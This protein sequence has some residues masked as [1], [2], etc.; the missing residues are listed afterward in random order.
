MTA[1]H[2]GAAVGPVH[3]G[4]GVDPPATVRY[5]VDAIGPAVAFYTGQ[6]GF[7]LEHRTDRSAVLKDIK[8]NLTLELAAPGAEGARP[9]PAGPQE[10]GGWTRIVVYVDDLQDTIDRL[11]QSGVRFRSELQHGPDG[12]E[13][14]IDDPDGNAVELHSMPK[15]AQR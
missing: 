13:I 2:A 8:D 9:T 3:A 6:L 12:A 4:A 5:Q 14:V 11:H 10:P 15:T 7:T 1:C